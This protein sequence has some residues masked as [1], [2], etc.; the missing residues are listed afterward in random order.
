MVFVVQLMCSMMVKVL[1]VCL[2]NICRSPAAAGMIKHL[3]KEEG[4]EIDLLAESCGLGDWHIG[5]LPDPRMRK[6]SRD[7][8]VILSTRAQQF[9]PSFLKKY[10][11]IFAADHAVLKEL[12][13]H[14]A[15]ATLK[16]KVHLITT[17]SEA[18]KGEDIPDPYL[19]G[20]EGFEVVLDMLEE[21][22][23]EILRAIE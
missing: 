8:G 6:A 18:Y 2:G 1:F 12:H 7:R 21:A 23:N 5:S 11:Y 17:F 16:H 10:D 13:K 3:A 14:A 15:S 22:C 20:A 19:G 4:S 9:K